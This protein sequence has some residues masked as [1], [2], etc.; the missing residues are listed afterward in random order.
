MFSANGT[1]ETITAPG[2]HLSDDASSTPSSP[3][4]PANDTPNPPVLASA[5]VVPEVEP[6]IPTGPSKR[7]QSS[8]ASPKDA[9]RPRL[10]TSGSFGQSHDAQSGNLS[11]AQSPPSASS[12]AAGSRASISARGGTDEDRRRGKRL[13]GGLLGTLAQ[14]GSSSR[15]S[16]KKQDVEEKLLAKQREQDELERKQ[17][18]KLKLE[19]EEREELKRLQRL[20]LDERR[21]GEQKAWDEQSVRVG[22]AWVYAN[23]LMFGIVAHTARQY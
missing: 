18:E 15:V 2:V 17:K 11:S 7:R 14:G 12:N 5:V 20:K 16:K 6:S 9:K 23:R 1:D 19:D 21:R 10:D 22:R 4:P 8:I 3:A 13:F